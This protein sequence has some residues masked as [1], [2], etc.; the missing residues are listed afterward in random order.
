MKAV[1]EIRRI[2]KQ[3]DDVELNIDIIYSQ[4]IDKIKQAAKEGRSE[5]VVHLI[6]CKD[7]ISLQLSYNSL[8]GRSKKVFDT[9]LMDGFNTNLYS[10]PNPARGNS[11][12][13]IRVSWE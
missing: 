9:F 2:K 7:L 3:H 4:Y 13:A 6:P 10:Y 12:F 5:L 1:D 11:N 8:K